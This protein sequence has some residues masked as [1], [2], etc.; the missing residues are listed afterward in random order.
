MSDMK[1]QQEQLRHSLECAAIARL[2]VGLAQNDEKLVKVCLKVGWG[3]E[4]RIRALLK[5]AKALDRN[6]E[7]KL[8]IQK[9]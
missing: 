2:W 1:S 6:A 4:E 7:I 8:Y 3:S 5:D 9:N